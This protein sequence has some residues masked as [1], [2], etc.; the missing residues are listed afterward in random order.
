MEMEMDPTTGAQDG[1]PGEKGAVPA[2]RI[3]DE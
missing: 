1:T 2:R 3:A